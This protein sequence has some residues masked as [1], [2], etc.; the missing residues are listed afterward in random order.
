[1]CYKVSIYQRQSVILKPTLI[2]GQLSAVLLFILVFDTL[3]HQSYA[4]NS[5]Q[6]FAID[7]GMNSTF[8]VTFVT[9]PID[10]GDII[11]YNAMDSN[12]R[13]IKVSNLYEI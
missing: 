12:H 11:C 13:Y 6:K 1:M 4:Q 5:N 3:A 9:S 2:A 8:T 7:K 10:S